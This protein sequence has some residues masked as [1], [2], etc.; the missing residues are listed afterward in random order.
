[1]NA[2]SSPTTRDIFSL[3]RLVD[4][5]PASLSEFMWAAREAEFDDVMLAFL[6][7]F[8]DYQ[9]FGTPK[10]FIDEAEALKRSIGQQEQAP[11]RRLPD[12]PG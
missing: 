12:P 7:R 10:E 6:A 2:L 5:Y 8:P 1:M 9:V 11:D 4:G 3:S